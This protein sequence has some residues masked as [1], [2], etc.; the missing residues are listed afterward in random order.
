MNYFSL[1]F[2]KY[3]IFG[4]FLIISNLLNSQIIPCD[5]V[6][7]SSASN[8]GIFNVGNY[9]EN[10]GIR[11]GPDYFGSTIFYPENTTHLLP[12]IIII[13][14]YANPELS[15]QAWGPFLASHGIVTMTI[16]TNN[17]FQYPNARKDALLDALISLKQ[18]NSRP[19]SPLYSKLDVNKLALAGW[20]MGGGGAQLAAAED[21]TLKAIVAL[22]PWLDPNTTNAST[23]NHNIPIIFVSSE[24][25]AIAPPSSHAEIQYQLT[26]SSTKKLIY[27]INN[28]GHTAANNPLNA[29]GDVGRMVLSWLKTYL[30]DD[31]CY[32]TLLLNIPNSSSSH[33]TNITCQTNNI[34]E[35][36]IDLILYPNPTKDIINI[37]VKS[38]INKEYKILD[39]N[40]KIIYKGSINN[41]FIIDISFLEPNIYFI[42]LNN[43][44]YKIIKIQ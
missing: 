21:T 32:C 28:A 20:S 8:S 22:C 16:G 23:V 38:W 19:S 33:E 27:E 3:M 44:Y 30:E 40:G 41:D 34:L 31:S 6:D 18:E 12:S 35:N 37:E 4:I 26:P 24:L 14:G 29:Q 10:D 43:K 7:I 5:S 2:K 42:C 39:L 25:D 17:I 15:M 13:P 9:S 11:N 1:F 36:I